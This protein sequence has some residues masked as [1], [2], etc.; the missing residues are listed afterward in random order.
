MSDRKYDA[1]IFDVD[2]T[3]F[4]TK[5]G[6]IM[7]MNRTAETQGLPPV[8]REDEDS[9]IGPPIQESYS[10]YYGISTDEGR[11]LAKIFRRYYRDD[12]LLECEL[13]DGMKETLRTLKNLGVKLCIATLKKQDMADRMAEAFELLPLMDS[14]HGTDE[15]DRLKKWDL[16]GFCLKDVGV[17]PQ[18]AVMIG[19]TIFDGEGAIRAGSAFLAATYGFG[20]Q[21]GAE[22]ESCPHIGEAHSPREIADFFV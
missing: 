16:I 10:R 12:Y 6:I 5:R 11:R 15:D 14:I 7:A 19:D 21:D 13:Y 8:R 1:A 4:D 3:L 2:G 9:F 22:L 20:F 18:R 17:K